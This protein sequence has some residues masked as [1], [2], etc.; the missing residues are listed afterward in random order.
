MNTYTFSCVCSCAIQRP[1][2]NIRHLFSVNLHLDFLR[3]CLPW[4]P[5][6]AELDQAVGMLRGD[7]SDSTL[8]CWGYIDTPYLA[9]HAR[10]GHLN[11]SH[12]AL[13]A[14]ALPT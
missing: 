5:E 4:N 1:E 10:A 11:S 8:Q 14:R 12:R 13:I 6:L 7:P 3:Q 9:L 2:V